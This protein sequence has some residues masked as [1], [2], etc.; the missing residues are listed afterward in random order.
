MNN[1]ETL[2]LTHL[3]TE[4]D[5][6]M[7]FA[8]VTLFPPDEMVAAWA[9]IVDQ[10]VAAHEIAWSEEFLAMAEALDYAASVERA[11]SAY[12]RKGVAL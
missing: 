5:G 7:Q 8:H 2:R 1:L 6:V 12:E 11:C 10:R 9:V 3:G 4:P